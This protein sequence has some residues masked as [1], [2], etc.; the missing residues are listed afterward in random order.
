MYVAVPGFTIQ[1]E[2]TVAVTCSWD[3]KIAARG[4]HLFIDIYLDRRDHVTP[5]AV[6]ILFLGDTNEEYCLQ[7]KYRKISAN[8]W[9]MYSS[10]FSR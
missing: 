5:S 8:S 6:D 3:Q 9:G 1:N 10:T 7:Y 4:N 2:R